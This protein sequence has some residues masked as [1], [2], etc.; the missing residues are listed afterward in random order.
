MLHGDIK[1][2]V[3]QLSYL[4]QQSNNSLLVFFSRLLQSPHIDV[5]YFAA[6]IVSHLS[7]EDNSHWEACDLSLD[8]MMNTL[9]RNTMKHYIEALLTQALSYI[10][11]VNHNIFPYKSR[12]IKT[13]KNRAGHWSFT[14]D[15]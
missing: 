3:S 12:V 1:Q 7:V 15:T 10:N 13:V 5:S 6:G 9:V 11:M 8:V 2:L 4:P 14:N